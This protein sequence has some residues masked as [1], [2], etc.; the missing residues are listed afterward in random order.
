MFSKRKGFTLVELLIVI[1]VIGILA[2]GMMLASGAATDSAKA[3]TLLAD[4][5]NAKAAGIAWFADNE[6]DIIRSVGAGTNPLAAI[7]AAWQDLQSGGT[8]HTMLQRYMDNEAKAGELLF[9]V[10]DS[11]GTGDDVWFLAGKNAIEK[12]VAEKAIKQGGGILL[13]INGVALVEANAVAGMNVYM[14]TK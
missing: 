3:A 1:I 9:A 14:R 6:N 8:S 5:R 7:T 2:G 4:L 13:S 12:K 11:G 10:Y